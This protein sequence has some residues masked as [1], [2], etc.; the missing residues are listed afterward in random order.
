ML[1]A[2]LFVL[3]TVALAGS[4]EWVQIVKKHP[5]NRELW[6]FQP[7]QPLANSGNNPVSMLG[8]WNRRA[9]DG[10]VLGDGFLPGSGAILLGTR[11][12]EGWPSG[13]ESAEPI[14]LAKE[15]TFEFL[16]RLEECPEN[17][18]YHNLIGWSWLERGQFAPLGFDGNTQTFL[19]AFGIGDIERR[20]LRWNIQPKPGHWIYA[21]VVVEFL[22]PREARVQ[23]FAADLTAGDKAAREVVPISRH[24]IDVDDFLNAG[25]HLRIGA[26]GFVRAGG[27]RNVNAFPVLLDALAITHSALTEE[28]LNVR[29]SALLKR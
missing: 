18:E 11:L 1:F 23:V 7:D 29:L 22:D 24:S 9:N 6:E 5:A 2:V 20:F 16:F 25:T 17:P 3:P 10:E 27:Q 15:V 14:L 13:L 12:E 4:A 28:D 21:A 19:S 8:N 26:D